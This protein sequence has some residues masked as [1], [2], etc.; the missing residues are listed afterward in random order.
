MKRNI[1]ISLILLISIGMFLFLPS[2]RKSSDTIRNSIL[3]E[4][5]LGSSMKQTQKF[6]KLRKWE[7][8]SISRHTGYYHSKLHR[9]IGKQSIRA[10]AGHYQSWLRVDVSIFFGFDSEDKL[11]DLYVRK[12]QEGI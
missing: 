2:I 4:L 10:Y 5:P 1:I 6:L 9:E 8:R 11:I 7:L 12:E 3:S